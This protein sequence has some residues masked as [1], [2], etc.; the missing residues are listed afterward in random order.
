[1]AVRPPAQFKRL[2]PG[3][4]P[5]AAALD[6]EILAEMAG[7]YARLMRVLE[8]ALAAL[9]AFDEGGELAGEMDNREKRG[10][11]SSDDHHSQPTPPAQPPSNDALGVAGPGERSGQE[12][13]PKGEARTG[14]SASQTDACPDSRAELVRNAGEA[15]WHVVIQRDVMRLSGTKQFLKELKV[16][17]EVVLAMGVR[18]ES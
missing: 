1:M 16:P 2:T 9:R 13:L 8:K 10:K 18:K 3:D 5:L 15:L 4:N 12:N 7:T 6:Q 14:V 17:A 11:V